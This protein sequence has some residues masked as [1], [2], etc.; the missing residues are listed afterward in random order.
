M[1]QFFW[2]I[3]FVLLSKVGRGCG[4]LVGWYRIVFLSPAARAE[5]ELADLRRL[6]NA[7]PDFERFV[8]EKLGD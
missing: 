1:K 3:A 2:A 8:F 6:M 7:L 5:A 4:R